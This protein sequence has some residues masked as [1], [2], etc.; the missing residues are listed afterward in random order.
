MVEK[1]KIGM[2]FLLFCQILYINRCLRTLGI[3]DLKFFY[4]KNAE[5]FQNG[6]LP[7]KF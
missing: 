5:L 2:F 3:K 4:E 6:T 7:G 1:T